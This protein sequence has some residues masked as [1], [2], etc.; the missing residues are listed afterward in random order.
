MARM[1]MDDNVKVLSLHLG[2]NIEKVIKG[3][4]PCKNVLVILQLL[5]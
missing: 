1:E 3:C 2:K 4:T 5:F